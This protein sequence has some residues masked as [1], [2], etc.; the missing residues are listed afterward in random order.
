MSKKRK[1][2]AHKQRQTTPPVSPKR[3][4]S[5]FIRWGIVAMV[6]GLGLLA[7]QII[8]VV[9]TLAQGH[10]HTNF[11]LLLSTLIGPLLIDAIMIVVGLI[12]LL[13]GLW[14]KRQANA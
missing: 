2:T 13:Y 14:Q 5:P 11:S 6:G 7:M 10:S 12:A 3:R 4:S 9:I 1:H 8:F